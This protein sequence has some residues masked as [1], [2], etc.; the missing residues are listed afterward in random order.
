MHRVIVVEPREAAH[1]ERDEQVE[2]EPEDHR[3][4]RRRETIELAQGE[5]AAET[6][7]EDAGGD[8]A[9]AAEVEDGEGRIPVVE[10]DVVVH[11]MA[12][13]LVIATEADERADALE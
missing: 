1:D 11:H 3:E 2:H 10:V 8:R 9:E 12:T 4:R 13:D 5:K 7:E 6:G